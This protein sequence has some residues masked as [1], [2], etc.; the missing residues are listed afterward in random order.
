[1]SSLYILCIQ[2][3]VQAGSEAPVL[4]SW[5]KKEKKQQKTKIKHITRFDTTNMHSKVLIGVRNTLFGPKKQQNKQYH[6]TEK[7]IYFGI[8]QLL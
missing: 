7:Y 6:V 4:L 2:C 5:K 1:M 3:T 8:I